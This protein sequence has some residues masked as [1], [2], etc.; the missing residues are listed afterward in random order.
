MIRTVA[1]R[2]RHPFIRLLFACTLLLQEVG[3]KVKKGVDGQF[4]VMYTLHR[5]CYNIQKGILT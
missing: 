1:I 5:D 2:Q 4:N 3:K